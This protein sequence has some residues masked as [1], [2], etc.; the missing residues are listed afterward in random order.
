MKKLFLTLLFACF[1][2]AGIQAQKYALVDMEYR[3]LFSIFI[4][5]PFCLFNPVH[6]HQVAQVSEALIVLSLGDRTV[7]KECVE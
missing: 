3:T 2:V 1:A 4:F 5:V 6:P 7:V